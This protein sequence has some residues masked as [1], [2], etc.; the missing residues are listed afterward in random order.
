MSAKMRGS[1]PPPVGASNG[2]RIDGKERPRDVGSQMDDESGMIE[3]GMQAAGDVE[4]RRVEL[5]VIGI[6]RVGMCNVARGIVVWGLSSGMCQLVCSAMRATGAVTGKAKG[7]SGLERGYDHGDGGS[8][9]I[10]DGV[11]DSAVFE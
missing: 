3:S 11:A 5:P 6:G 7:A 8:R 10:G 4:R 1:S 9:S 2:C